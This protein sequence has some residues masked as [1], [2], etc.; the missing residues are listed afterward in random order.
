MHLSLPWYFVLPTLAALVSPNSCHHHLLP[1]LRGFL[2]FPWVSPG[3]TMA[4]RSPK[5]GCTLLAFHFSGSPALHCLMSRVLQKVVFRVLPLCCC[6]C[7]RQKGKASP[8]PFFFFIV[9]F[10]LL[11][12]FFICLSLFSHWLCLVRLLFSLWFIICF[13]G[14]SYLLQGSPWRGEVTMIGLSCGFHSGYWPHSHSLSKL[15]HPLPAATSSRADYVLSLH[16]PWLRSLL[17]PQV[18]WVLTL[19]AFLLK[20]LRVAATGLLLICSHSYFTKDL[21]ILFVCLFL[22]NSEYSIVSKG[23]FGFYYKLLCEQIDVSNG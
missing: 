1:E 2:G 21:C 18:L 20:W 12:F 10:I 3:C 19:W 5:T 7:F 15:Q 9:K 17:R 14:G 22:R 6:S 8:C 13:E 11:F 23:T 4:W 16:P